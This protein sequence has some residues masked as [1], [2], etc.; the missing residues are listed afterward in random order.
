VAHKESTYLSPMLVIVSMYVTNQSVI[1]VRKDSSSEQQS[2]IHR[3]FAPNSMMMLTNEKFPIEMS[4]GFMLVITNACSE[5][6]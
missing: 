2:N 5:Q 6:I 3:C 1:I 4:T